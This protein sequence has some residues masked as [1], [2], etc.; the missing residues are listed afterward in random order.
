LWIPGVSFVHCLV[1][2]TVNVMSFTA[3]NIANSDIIVK[4]NNRDWR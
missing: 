3:L 4:R 1:A 2:A